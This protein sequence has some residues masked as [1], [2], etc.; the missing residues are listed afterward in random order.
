MNK[1]KI[2]KTIKFLM[3]ADYAIKPAI[4]VLSLISLPTVFLPAIGLAALGAWQLF[5]ALLFGLLQFSETR[6]IYLSCALV[7]L[8]T[9]WAGTQLIDALELPEWFSTPFY[10]IGFILLPI[11]AGLIYYSYAKKQYWELVEEMQ[12][13]TDIV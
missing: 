6:F 5:S 1:P 8:G 3:L 4:I 13:S 2:M 9:L 11:A 10:G 12:T 7:Y